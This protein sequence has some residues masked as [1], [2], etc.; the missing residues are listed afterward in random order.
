MD[1]NARDR[2]TASE[3]AGLRHDSVYKEA[4]KRGETLGDDD[5]R[6]LYRKASTENSDIEE[7]KNARKE[8]IRI[9]EKKPEDYPGLAIGG[10][11]T[12]GGMAQVDSGEVYL[13]KNS[14]QIIKE[15][16]DALAAQN[17]IAEKQNTHL[18]AI[19][20]RDPNFYLNS[21]KLNDA[22]GT[23]ILG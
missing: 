1:K 20:A 4:A 3:Q 14:L 9:G 16:A 5:L 18:A 17:Q 6:A 23:S 19:A 22:L 15:M 21:I 11:V 12:K 2:A 7:Q 13:G 10:L 8:L